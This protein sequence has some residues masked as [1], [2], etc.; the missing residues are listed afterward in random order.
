MYAVEYG[1]DLNGWL[2]YSQLPIVRLPYLLTLRASFCSACICFWGQSAEAFLSY[3][4]LSS[5]YRREKSLSLVLIMA[6]LSQ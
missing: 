5:D 2:F 3:H 1:C 4:F 6:S